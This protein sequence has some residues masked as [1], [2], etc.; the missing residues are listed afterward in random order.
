MLFVIV[1]AASGTLGLSKIVRPLL[2]AGSE[3]DSLDL[4]EAEH[5]QQYSSFRIGGLGSIALHVIEQT[6]SLSAGRDDIILVSSC[7]GCIVTLEIANRMPHPPRRVVLLDPVA[8]PFLTSGSLL[9]FHRQNLSALL[10]LYSFYKSARK[11]A[12]KAPKFAKFALSMRVRRLWFYQRRSACK[13]TVLVSH[14]WR[15]RMSNSFFGRNLNP[16]FH[17]TDLS[18]K[19][20]FYSARGAEEIRLVLEKAFQSSLSEGGT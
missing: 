20:I 12:A 16:D 5:E 7:S 18:H 1:P 17:T 6:P 4:V 8:I 2:P 10:K 14:R 3:C 11:K 13:L 15:K 19:D 9:E